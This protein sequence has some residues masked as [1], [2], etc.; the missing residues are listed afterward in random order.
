MT[1]YDCVCSC[2][3]VHMLGG[4]VCVCSVAGKL[5]VDVCVCVCSYLWIGV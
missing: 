1:V 4:D 3:V 5:F 2:L